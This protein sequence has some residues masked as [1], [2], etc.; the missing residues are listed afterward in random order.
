MV[1]APS[2]VLQNKKDF[3]AMTLSEFL[4]NV[5]ARKNFMFCKNANGAQNTTEI[6]SIVQT[7]R[8]N[9]VK[10]EEYLKYIIEN[11]DKIPLEKLLPWH[12]D[13]PDELRIHPEDIR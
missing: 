4:D 8:G 13:L 11:I 5:V 9:G 3:L 10:V 12:K 2:A 6:F 1:V 7:A